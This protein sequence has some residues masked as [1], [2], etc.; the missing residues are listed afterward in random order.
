MSAERGDSL[1]DAIRRGNET[2]SCARTTHG[3]RISPVASAKFSRRTASEV[4]PRREISAAFGG[5]FFV[6]LRASALGSVSLEI[7][8]IN[9]M[10][11]NS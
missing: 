7:T 2:D 5:P 3:I 4:E 9:R 11:D 6:V 1:I 10:R 8:I